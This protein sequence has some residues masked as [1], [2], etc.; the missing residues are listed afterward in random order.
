LFSKVIANDGLVRNGIILECKNLALCLSL[1][2]LN[3]LLAGDRGPLLRLRQICIVCRLLQAGF[4]LYNDIQAKVFQ[5][6][7]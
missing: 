1:R 2:L 4:T 3:G 5:A 6:F 7:Y